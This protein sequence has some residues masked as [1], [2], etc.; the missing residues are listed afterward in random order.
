MRRRRRPYRLWLIGA[1]SY[2]DAD[3]V[4]VGSVGTGFME[5]EV[6]RLRKMLDKLRWK[7]EQSSLTYSERADTV[8]VEP[9]LIAAVEFRA[10]TPEGELRHPSY[11]GLRE[12]QDNAA[13]LRQSAPSARLSSF[14][15]T[16]SR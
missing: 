9:T 4:R 6:I 16:R 10:W 5:A 7:R 15:L 14:E 8:W 2:R 1:C 3:L 12:R 13:V 11:K